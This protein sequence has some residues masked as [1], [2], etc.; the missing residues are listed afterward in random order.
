VNTDR[1]VDSFYLALEE[2]NQ[3]ELLPKDT[4]F[5]LNN[6]FKEIIAL[7]A[8]DAHLHFYSLFSQISWVSATYNFPNK[9]SFLCQKYRRICEGKDESPE[10]LQRSFIELGSHLCNSL[11]KVVQDSNHPVE[12]PQ[13]MWSTFAPQ[14]TETFSYK[15]H[16]EGLLISIDEINHT[17]I[18]Q[19]E[20][21][22]D[23]LY[24]VAYD[25]AAHN[26]LFTTNLLSASKILGIPYPIN[27]VDVQINDQNILTPHAFVILPDLLVDVTSIANAAKDAEG[28]HWLYMLNKLYHKEPSTAVMIGNLANLILDELTYDPNITYDQLLRLFFNQDPLKWSL[29][30]DDET[31]ES[32]T[33]LQYHFNNLKKVINED[34][35]KNNIATSNLY[36]EPSFYCRAYGIQGRLDMLH[37]DNKAGSSSII[38]L[39]TSKPFKPNAYGISESHYLQTLLYD[40]IISTMNIGQQKNINFILYSS[41]ESDNLRYAPSTKSKQAELI[42]TRNEIV[43]MEMALAKNT[44]LTTKIIAFMKSNNFTNIKGFIKNDLIHYEALYASLNEAEREY[45][46]HHISFI[47]KEYIHAKIGKD[48]YAKGL[49]KMWLA[50]EEEKIA[51]Y[52]LIN[53]LRIVKND[54]DQNPPLIQFE[55]TE[56]ST[57]LSSFRI[58]DIVVLYPHSFRSGDIMRHQVFKCN[59]IEISPNGL[60][61]R[62]RSHQK[63]HSIFREVEF[64]NVEQDVLDSSFRHMNKNL[65][66]YIS[67]DEE[68]RKL[69]MGMA[70]PRYY[71]ME[72][73]LPLPD[74]L[75]GEQKN[76]IQKIFFCK[77]YFLVWG[78]PGTG[79]TS[80]VIK[81]VAK[82]FFEY[83]NKKILYLAYTNKAVDEICEAITEAGLREEIVRIGSTFSV[84]PAYQDR[85]LHV[86]IDALKSRKKITDFTTQS[87]IVVSTLSSIMGKM[88]LF[89]L[90]EFDMIVVDEAS[91]IIESM[92][93]GILTKCNRFVLIGDHKQLPA[94]VS[95]ELDQTAIN[96]ATLNNAGITHASMSLFERL[97]RQGIKNNW[98]HA[99]Q[100][101]TF[102]GRM[103]V[104]IMQFVNIHFYE[105]KLKCLNNVTRLHASN[106]SL[107]Y[108]H[109]MLY[110]NTE[111]NISGNIKTN[112]DEAIKA[113][114]ICKSIINQYSEKGLEIT[115]FTIGIIIPYRAQISMIKKYLTEEE[116]R[117]ISIDTVERYQGAARDIIILSLCTNRI[118]QLDFIAP[119]HADGI[120][121]KLNVALTRAK[122]Q[123][124]ILGNKD[125]L[126]LN[127]VYHALIKYSHTIEIT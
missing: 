119:A 3:H 120:N 62:L 33:K 65:F 55:Y 101:L 39:K 92:L 127:P 31:K 121:R 125:I 86:Q 100:I 38:E 52:S 77:D 10:S 81:H 64:W 115:P 75:T 29:L 43:L 14:N 40:L 98:V 28:E 104:D 22:H 8:K 122:E 111:S 76:I 41:L 112:E 27:L 63:N 107:P 102:Q 37:V 78:P 15:K 123:I 57:R 35:T 18:F 71:E 53:Y 113:V 11:L 48:D 69:L 44:P 36:L 116:S 70:P 32:L 89:D 118:S 50:T 74:D 95:Q 51:S 66:L 24:T 60:I 26:D 84:S 108:Q 117:L 106:T 91:Q 87:R 2:I 114:K 126:K 59:I 61:L 110:I 7:L 4:L 47:A 34:F 1:H 82:S 46:S 56:Y 94:V 49:S 68:K 93:I 16:M 83:T 72:R 99:Q 17:F 54:A 90:M 67:A 19:P 45:Y 30:S 6:L 105:S 85:L 23:V 73:I 80:V 103:H 42:K 124:Y 21:N 25:V 9:F 97:Y 79:K 13:H 5:L 20:Q 12:V 88:E 109:R 96:H 58:G